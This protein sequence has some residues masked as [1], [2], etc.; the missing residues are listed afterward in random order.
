[1]AGR[2]ENLK[3]WPKG[4][5]GNPGGRPKRDMAAEIAQAVFEQNP[6]MIYQAMAKKLLK[7]DAHVFRELANRAFGKVPQKVEGNVN[8]S[9][10]SGASRLKELLAIAIGRPDPVAALTAEGGSG[11]SVKG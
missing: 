7:G 4:V 5:S 8:F 11:E 6:E 9:S 3:P 10:E 1:M 2:I